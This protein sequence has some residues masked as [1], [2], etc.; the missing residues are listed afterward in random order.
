MPNQ[1]F[2]NLPEDKRQ[3]IARAAIEEFSKFSYNEASI[4]QICKKGQMAKGSFYQYFQ[5]KQ[6]LYVYV[7]TLANSL[8]IEFFAES[9]EQLPN[10]GLLEQVRLLYVKGVEFARKYPMYAALGDKFTKEMDELAKSAVL[11]G[12]DQQAGSF[13]EVLIQQGKLRGEIAE[14]VSTVALA[15]LLQTLNQTV[16]EHMMAEYGSLDYEHHEKE[17]HVFVEEIL[18]ILANGVLRKG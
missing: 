13:F 12:T 11:K 16:Y 2:F 7:M 15:K 14:S 6:D 10:L 17:M 5:D 18:A 9:L 3:M 8:K 1:T 4:N